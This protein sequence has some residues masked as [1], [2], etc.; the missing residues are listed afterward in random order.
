[1]K[2]CDHGDGN[3]EGGKK[4][5]WRRGKISTDWMKKHSLVSSVLRVFLQN[6]LQTART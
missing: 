1:M 3:L 6:S 2:G 5:K 4:K